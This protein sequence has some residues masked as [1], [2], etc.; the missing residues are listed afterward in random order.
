MNDK[1]TPTPPDFRALCAELLAAVE[2]QYGDSPVDRLALSRRARAA[3]EAQPEPQGPDL[4]ACDLLERFI[5]CFWDEQDAESYPNAAALVAQARALL[6]QPEPQGPSDQ[7]LLRIYRVATPCYQV[8]EYK[9]ELDFARAVLARW[10]RPAIEPVSQGLTD[11]EL[12]EMWLSQEW[13]NEGATFREFASI[14]RRWGRPAIEPVPVSERLPGPEDCDAEGRCWLH[15]PHPATPETSEWKL[16]PARQASIIY[17]TTHWLPY[18]ALPV[19]VV[20]GA[21][22]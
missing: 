5:D 11:E 1:P 6:A 15:Q 4:T 9:R 14:V 8:E 19:P 7:E 18:W 12:R 16:I 20:E 17:N 21:D 3:L 13:F 22:G 2:H 10:G